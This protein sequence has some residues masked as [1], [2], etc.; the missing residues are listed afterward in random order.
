MFISHEI[1]N[2][3]IPNVCMQQILRATDCTGWNDVY[4][5]CS[6]L[7]SFERAF[8]QI[9]PNAKFYGNDVSL[10]S[11][12]IAAYS[13][14]ESVPFKFKGRVAHW[15]KW[16][17][18]AGYRDRIS[19][20]LLCLYLG[21]VYRSDND[22]NNRHWRY[23]E[24]RFDQYIQKL[25][26]QVDDLAAQMDL[27]GY[28]SGDFIDHLERGI[29]KDAALIISAPFIQGWYEKWFRFI[30]ENIEWEQPTYNMW[31]PENFPALIDRMDES[32]CNYVAVYKDELPDRNMIAYHRL[33]MKPPFYV[34]ANR[35]R[36]S[37]VVNRSLSGAGTAFNFTAIDIDKLNKD[38]K[39]EIFACKAGS[40]DY[41]KSLY[42]Q[43]NIPWTSGPVNFLIYVDKMLA[44]ILTFSA[45]KV[46]MGDIS[47]TESLYLLSDTSTTRYGRVSKLIAMIAKSED[48]L[49]Y[50]ENRL[51][52]HAE[53]KAV[54]TTVRSNHPV[55]MKYRGIFKKISTK[56][57]APGERSGAKFIVNYA[58][59]RDERGPQ[60]IYAEWFAKSFKDDRNR[61]VKTS[62]SK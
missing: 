49:H 59:L 57:P 22:Y 1:F 28:F 53:C 58:G 35:K 50:A 44:G 54:L 29:E 5:G 20:M 37:S 7:F 16:L 56:E 8:K 32:G 36:V 24:A 21:R 46:G 9:N 43:E 30:E 14:G 41:I 13:R 51:L 52:K 61:N 25:G 11:A 47:R 34:Y 33:G 62:Y 17:E 19:A 18:G 6:G 4:V 12:A 55:S 10:M 31:S 2:G 48:V 42:L 60:Q 23:Y 45:S 27:T 38:S 15:E 3:S 39:V 26:L 40:A